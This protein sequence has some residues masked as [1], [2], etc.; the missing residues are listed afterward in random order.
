VKWHKEKTAIK[1]V[2]AVA[3]TINLVMAALHQ[4]STWWQ[5]LL[6][7]ASYIAA[8]GENIKTTINLAACFSVS[9]LRMMQQH[10]SCA[11]DGKNMQTA[12]GHKGKI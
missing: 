2:V 8:Q 1:L 4:Q 6:L 11:N 9:L 10:T 5:Q 7:L 12:Q 3:A